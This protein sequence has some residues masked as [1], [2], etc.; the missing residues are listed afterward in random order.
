MRQYSA[1]MTHRVRTTQ[2]GTASPSPGRAWSSANAER[3]LAEQ[4]RPSRAAGGARRGGQGERILACDGF[5]EEGR[6]PLQIRAGTVELQTDAPESGRRPAERG[7]H[8]PAAAEVCVD[9]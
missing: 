9:D 6:R 5:G 7:D 8:V 4:E 1:C 3:E 2:A